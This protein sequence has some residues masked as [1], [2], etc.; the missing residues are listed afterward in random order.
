MTRALKE[1]RETR[2]RLGY[3]GNQ[4]SL[5]DQDRWDPKESRWLVHQASLEFPVH[6]VSQATAEQ[7]LLALL[8]HQGPLGHPQDMAQL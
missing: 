1:R 2:E 7:D 4:A 3:P 5:G 6:Q 8:D